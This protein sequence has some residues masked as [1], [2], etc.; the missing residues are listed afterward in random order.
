[1]QDPVKNKDELY[2]LVKDLLSKEE[3]D[4][5][6]EKRY[7]EYDDLLDKETIALL[8]VDERGRN[9]LDWKKISQL[10]E[11]EEI[12]IQLKV[13]NIGNLKCFNK[14]NGRQGHVINIDV[15]DDTGKCRLTLWDKDVELVKN[16]TIK[17]GSTVKLIDG[18]VRKTK[19]GIEIGKGRCGMLIID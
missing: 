4:D 16:K 7:K 13:A 8:I 18:F 11:N 14:K 17:K 15:V 9:E 6:I 3:F 19:F 5:E 2:A 12:M 10:E 1:M